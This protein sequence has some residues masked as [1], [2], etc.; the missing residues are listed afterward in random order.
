MNKGWKHRVSKQWLKQHITSLTAYGGLVFC[1]VLFSVL[2]PL[3]GESIWSERKLAT[4]MSNVIVTALMSVGAVFVYALGNMDISIGRQVGLYATIMVL[5]GNSTGSLWLPILVCVLLSVVFAFLNGATGDL[6][7]MHP[8]IPSLVLMFVLMGVSSLI[9]VKLGTRNIALTSMSHEVFKSPWL[10]LAALAAEVLVVS[11]LFKY[12]KFGK[13]ARAIGANQSATQQSG[14]NLIKYKVIAYI[15]MGVC[16]VI[17]SIFQM[18]YTGAASDATGTGFEMDVMVALILGGMPLSGG[19]RSKVSCAVVGAFT[20]ALLDVGLPMIG[21][22]TK[23]TFI[24]KAVIFMV[25]VFITC[26]KKGGVLPR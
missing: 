5:L 25:V 20:F 26:R 13:Y 6:L 18:G 8:I 22:P 15:I 19:M 16:V 9:Y 3:F 1:I 14:V 17:A 21:I 23:V 10:M 12:T 2:T 11:Y 4:L 24:I 7:K